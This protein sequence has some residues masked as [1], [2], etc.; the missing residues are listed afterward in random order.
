M[1]ARSVTAF[2]SPFGPDRGYVVLGGYGAAPSGRSG[3]VWRLDGVWPGSDAAVFWRRS[4][5]G[6]ERGGTGEYASA[7]VC[8]AGRRRSGEGQVGGRRVTLGGVDILPVH[9]TGSVMS[10]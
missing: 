2:R 8:L 7:S 6:S 10:R 3:G 9:A 1:S 5:A 4:D